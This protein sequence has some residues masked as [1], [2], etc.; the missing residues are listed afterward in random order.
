LKATSW[1]KSGGSANGAWN[2]TNAANWSNGRPSAGDDVS[3]L[4]INGVTSYTVTLGAN[5]AKLGS[6]TFGRG[7]G[8][9]LAIGAFALDVTAGTGGTNL[10]SVS[11]GDT[12]TIAKAGSL[13]AGGLTLNGTLTGA[14]TITVQNVGTTSHAINGSGTITAANGTLDLVGTVTSGLTFTIAKGQPSVL[15]FDGTATANQTGGITINNSNQILEIGATGDLTIG[16]AES[17]T[18]GTIQLD[19]GSLTDTA[20][21]TVSSGAMLTG[22]GV[23]NSPLTGSGGVI[24]ASGGTLDLT[25][26]VTGTSSLQIDSATASVLKIDG[27]ASALAAIAISSANQTLEIGGSGRLTIGAAENITNG[28]IQLGGGSLTDTTGITVGTGATLTGKGTVNGPLTGRGGVIR[29]SGGTFDLTGNVT[30]GASLQIDAASASVLK[31]DGTATAST[32]I[33][34]TSSN[35]TLEIGPSGKLTLNAL[36]SIIDGKIQLDGGSLTAVSGVTIG[37]GATL[38]G[39]GSIFSSGATP[40]AVTLAGGTVSQSGGMLTVGSITGNGTVSGVTGAG[41]ITARGG[42]LDLTGSVSGAALAI[43]TAS[44]RSTLKIDGTASSAAI[45]TSSV[46]QTLEIG[47]SGKL[48]LNAAETITNGNIQVDGGSLI[49]LAG[50]T[51]GSGGTLRLG[52]AATVGHLAGPVTNAVSSATFDVVNADL[53]G[54]GLFTG[55]NSQ[56][57]LRNGST[58]GNATIDNDAYMN[59]YDTSTAGSSQLSNGGDIWFNDYTTA[60][61]ALISTTGFTYFMGHS[62]AGLAQLTTSNAPQ[63][64][65]VFFLGNSTAGNASLIN[66]GSG[67]VDFSQTT[68][69]GGDHKISAGSIAGAGAFHLGSDQLTVGADNTSTTVSGAIQDGGLGGGVG[70]SLV[71]TGTGTL[72]LSGSNSYTGGTTILNG[73]LRINTAIS[74]TI[75]NNG[76]E[77]VYGTATNTTINGGAEIVEVGGTA[78]GTVVNYEFAPDGSVARPMIVYGTA[79]NTTINNG[80]V[81]FVYGTDSNSTIT[82]GSQVVEAGATT[83]G[84]H[85]I[86]GNQFVY[87]TALNATIESDQVV[88]AGGTAT[89]T[90]VSGSGT[91]IVYGTA[92]NTT[93]AGG[94]SQG[95]QRIYSG[96][97]ATGTMLNSSGVEIVD[98]GGTAVDTIINGGKIQLDGGSL[99]N[100]GGIAIGSGATLIGK[101]TVSGPVTGSGTGVIEAS[102]GT[103]ELTGSVTGGA[104]LQ[105]DATLASVLKIDS[106]TTASAAIAIGSANQTLEIGTAASLTLSAAENITNGRIQLDGGS[107][108]DA[109]GLTIGDGAALIGSGTVTAPLTTTGT[110]IIEVSGGALNLS[111]TVTGALS[112]ATGSAVTLSLS[113]DTLALTGS[114]GAVNVTGFNDTIT[115]TG[116]NDTVT[117]SGSNHSNALITLVSDGASLSYTER[118]GGGTLNISGA[119]DSVYLDTYADLINITGTNDSVNEVTLGNTVNVVGTN[120]SVSLG[121]YETINI[122]GT[123]DRVSLGQGDV[124]TV[125]GSNAIVTLAGDGVTVTIAGADETVRDGDGYN[126]INVTNNAS[127]NLSLNGDA[128]NIIGTNDSLRITGSA[129]V[130]YSA[131]N[132]RLNLSASGDT[133]QVVG[134]NATLALAGD[135]NSVVITGVGAQVTLAGSGDT[136]TLSGGVSVTTAEGR[137]HLSPTRISVRTRSPPSIR[138][139]TCCSSILRCLQTMLPRWRAQQATGWVIRSL[140]MMQTIRSRCWAYRRPACSPSIFVLPESLSFESACDRQAIPA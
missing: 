85:D 108:T 71:K 129:N 46:N 77:N 15:K 130:T 7:A 40:G 97:A 18:N 117:V 69:P 135:N 16:A 26:S 136:V 110:G 56:T 125:T 116:S 101:G 21:I 37:S 28:K 6:L 47:A 20:G 82:Y 27:N 106:A 114:S 11:S 81:E 72:T 88:Q 98:S 8:A 54:I 2:S 57:Y 78:M 86:G 45:A 10:V 91:Q 44:P 43:D 55:N 84:L 102:G 100:T 139:W 63:G 17:I 94:G 22:K 38:A 14:G 73:T 132:A 87:G 39:S 122:S 36:E 96:G 62:T 19:G 95:F 42:I 119:N 104:S 51:I 68:G 30:A 13:T 3:F 59:F 103:L 41:S 89:N 67:Y 123:A 74:D 133:I 60:G 25:G 66:V 137:T 9:T 4:A 80:G 128:V 79:S 92:N 120:D 34:I 5:T 112:L 109:A 127:A 24:R 121:Y 61:S 52:T 65:A 93:V 115:L 134:N 126:M 140:P 35:Q 113:N 49:D 12:I 131:N 107:L 75:V 83:T 105:I 29:A 99:T 70:G 50:F 118:G 76:E 90:Q 64:G 111:G 33:A 58:A 48:T 32:A 53:S 23:V 138:L 1:Q 124:A 31:I